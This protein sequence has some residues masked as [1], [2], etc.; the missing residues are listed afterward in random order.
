MAF[1]RR[2]IGPNLTE[3]ERR[4]TWGYL[5]SLEDPPDFW[6]GETFAQIVLY[7]VVFF[8]YCTGIAPVTSFFL[9]FCFILLESGYRYQYIHNYPRG[10]DSGGTLWRSF[11]YFC[12]GSLIIG[13]LTV[14]GLLSLKAAYYA[15]PAMSPLIAATV[16]FIFFINGV[17]SRVSLY[18]PT[19]DCM[20]LDDRFK[21]E[22][23]D[24]DF[25]VNA[26]LQPAL[27]D[28][29]VEPDYDDLD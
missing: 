13:E 14:M 19:R 16:L 9:Y 26:Y 20:V 24:L 28:D 12:F 3:K 8:V 23:R 1:L 25:V 15:V 6:H 10:F 5:N 7:F 17:H 29:V 22:G 11:L 4:R 2:Y 27:R 21:Q 18:L